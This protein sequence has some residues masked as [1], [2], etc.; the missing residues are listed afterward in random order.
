MLKMIF[1]IPSLPELPVPPELVEQSV[2]F[3]LSF[4]R[5]SEI[6][7]DFL[8]FQKFKFFK[9]QFRMIIILY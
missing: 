2:D 8:L 1:A 6:C 4:S 3:V 7:V 5:N 9:L